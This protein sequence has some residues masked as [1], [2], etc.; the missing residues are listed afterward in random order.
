MY[1]QAQALHKSGINVIS[2]DEKTGIQALERVITPMKRGQRERQDYEY[3]R[4]G[5]QCLIANFEIATGKIICPTLGNTRTEKDFEKHIRQT[6]STSPEAS[7]IFIVDNLNIHQ[8]ESLVRYV[9]KVCRIKKQLGKK[10]KYGILKSM[11]TRSAFL[12]DPTHRIRFVYTPKHASW[13]NQ[14]ECWFSILVKRLLK[15]LSVKST[16][17]LS[18]KIYSFIDYFNATMAKA[19]K[20]TYKGSPLNV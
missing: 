8:S 2:C 9:A 18:S 4:H 12:S 19:F 10:G 1:H 11:E 20:W 16:Q 5:T 17:E 14:V 6:V 15:R 3:E 13:L 7:W